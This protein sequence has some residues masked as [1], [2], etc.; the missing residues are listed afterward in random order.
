MIGCFFETTTTL[1]GVG[2][3]G[4]M[5]VLTRSKACRACDEAGSMVT[6]GGPVLRSP[7]G[8]ASATSAA[9]AIAPAG[10]A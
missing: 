1:N 7:A 6:S 3:P 2:Q 9:V 8:S 5:T 4:P 10:I